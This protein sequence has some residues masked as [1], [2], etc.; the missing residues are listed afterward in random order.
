VRPLVIVALIGVGSAYAEWGPAERLP[1]T[2]NSPYYDW[3]VCVSADGNT[4]YFLSDRGGN[5]DI[6]TS[7]R[8]GDGWTLATRLPAPINSSGLEGGPCLGWNGR[9]LYFDRFQSGHGYIYVA[10]REGGGWGTPYKIPGEVNDDEYDVTNPA[11]SADGSTLYFVGQEWPTNQTYFNIYSSQWTGAGW[12][13]PVYLTGINTVYGE[14]DPAPTYDGRY[15]YFV[16]V[17]SH[18]FWL[19][20]AV[21]VGNSW[22]NPEPLGPNVNKPNYQ[23]MDPSVT[24]NGQYLFFSRAQLNEYDIYVSRWQEPAVEPMSIGRVKALFR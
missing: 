9:R 2:V 19:Y 6:Y 1:D 10:V 5:M 23:Q 20:R 21:R 24:A 13:K 12:G 11:V 16:S 15:L 8:E 4:I 18:Y 3:G 14:S 17:R 7:R 22:G